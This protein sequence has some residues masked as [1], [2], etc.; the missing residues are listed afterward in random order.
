MTILLLVLAARCTA[1]APKSST[2]IWALMDGNCG[3]TVSVLGKMGSKLTTPTGHF[4]GWNE[5]GQFSLKGIS[6][7]FDVGP[8]EAEESKSSSPTF[9]RFGRTTVSQ[10]RST[11]VFFGSKS[12]EI[13]DLRVQERVRS[14][15]AGTHLALI[16]F[17]REGIK[18]RG[19]DPAKR[20]TSKRMPVMIKG[21]R[22]MP[23]IREYSSAISDDGSYCFL[24]VDIPIGSGPVLDRGGETD[25]VLLQLDLIRINLADGEATPLAIVRERMHPTA[26]YA[27]MEHRMAL[28]GPNLFL[29]HGRSLW[30]L[31]GVLP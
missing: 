23:G 25:G 6:S 4:V 9:F 2:D 18:V 17:E 5:S 28:A 16:D 22:V 30:V 1:L 26:Y 7:V 27:T 15:R 14:N 29:A 20:K 21:K 31:S 24:V 19:V 12:F 8:D 10:L 3:Q 13:N 11:M